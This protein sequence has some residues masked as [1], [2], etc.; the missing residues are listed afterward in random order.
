MRKVGN[1]SGVVSMCASRRARWMAR[2]RS[3]RSGWWGPVS[4]S[5]KRGREEEADGHDDE[6]AVVAQGLVELLE[7]GAVG[8]ELVVDEVGGE[9]VGEGDREGGGD[10]GGELPEEDADEQAEAVAREDLEPPQGQQGD[11]E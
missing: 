3:G 9:V 8:F 11:G 2:R 7:A 10:G 1:G 5:T 4:W 6:Q